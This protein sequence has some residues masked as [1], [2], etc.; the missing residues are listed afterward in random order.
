[1]EHLCQEIYCK[2]LLA[3]SSC[4]N[5]T[6]FCTGMDLEECG[7]GGGEGGGVLGVLYRLGYH[8][9]EWKSR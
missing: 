5:I 6:I 8:H 2:R 1:M 9:Q 3:L 7:S 4:K